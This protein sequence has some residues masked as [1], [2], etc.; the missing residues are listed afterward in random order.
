MQ[1][2]RE[3][4]ARSPVRVR[5]PGLHLLLLRSARSGATT[6]AYRTIAQCG[7]D[8]TK[9]RTAADAGRDGHREPATSLQPATQ[10]SLAPAAPRRAARRAPPRR[11]PSPRAPVLAVRPRPRSPRPDARARARARSRPCPSRAIAVPRPAT[12]STAAHPRFELDSKRFPTLHALGRNLTLAAS[13]G[14]LDPVF[15]REAEIDRAL[16][17]LAKRHGNCPCLVGPA[18]VGKT[19]VVR[20][21]AQR[22]ADGREV[23]TLDDRIVVEL[24]AAS[25]L[26]GTGVRGALAERIAQIKAEVARSEGRVVLFFDELHALLTS[27]DEKWPPS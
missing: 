9:L 27:D 6:A 12:P 4:A 3:L 13:R 7:S 22:I 21:L 2:A 23:A 24:E 11:M 15:G 20:G 18:G 1:R 17:V 25:L 10:L 26:A 5:R 8:V 19:S 14:E 16:D